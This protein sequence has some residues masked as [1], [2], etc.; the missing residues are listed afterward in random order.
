MEITLALEHMSIEEKIRAMEIIWDDLCKKADS[1]SAPA[2]H[3]DVLIEREDQIKNGNAEFMD[4]NEAKKHIR[5][6]VL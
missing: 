6:K 5:D 2:W 1:I 3:K 4:W